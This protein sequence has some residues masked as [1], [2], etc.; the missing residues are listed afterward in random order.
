MIIIDTGPMVALFDKDDNYHKD[1]KRVL[2]QIREPLI[3]TWPVITEVMYLL[4]FSF[5]TQE[6]CLDFIE[7]GGVDIHAESCDRVQMIHQI[8]KKYKDLPMDFAD[9]SLLILAEEKGIKTIF[10][11]D[12]RDFRAF[13]P[14]HVSSFHIIPE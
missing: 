9:A 6:L 14:R 3:T 12:N 13:A 1:C 10:T 5:L 2:A 4:N 8:M 7:S 11:L